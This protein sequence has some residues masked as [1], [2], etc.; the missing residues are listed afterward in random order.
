M[1]HGILASLLLTTS[2]LVVACSAQGP[3]PSACEIDEDCEKGACRGGICV[4][5]STPLVDPYDP[6]DSG[7]PDASDAA[8]AP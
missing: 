3:A 2:S 1:R 8:V 4:F 5:F 6:G 7:P